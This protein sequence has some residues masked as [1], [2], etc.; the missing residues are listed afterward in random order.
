MLL[1]YLSKQS[2][3]SIVDWQD[4]PGFLVAGFCD[5]KVAVV[6]VPNSRRVWVAWVDNL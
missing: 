2:L 6:G 5:F 1:A 3:G 4:V